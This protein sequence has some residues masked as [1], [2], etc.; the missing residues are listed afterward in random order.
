MGD[1][2]DLLQGW[3]EQLSAEGIV[4]MPLEGQFWGDLYGDVKDKYGIEWMFNI[5][6]PNAS[7]QPDETA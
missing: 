4:G 1:D 5:S 2:V 6:L 3:Y 7:S